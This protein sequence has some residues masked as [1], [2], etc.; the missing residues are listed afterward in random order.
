MDKQTDLEI[1]KRIAE[2]E[3]LVFCTGNRYARIEIWKD[4]KVY[5]Y[6][7]Y[8]PLTDDA[9]CFK[10]MLKY[11]TSLTYGGYA[12]IAEALIKKEDGEHSFATQAYCPKRAICLAIIA[13]KINE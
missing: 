5:K 2:I 7:K 12:V 11:E 10:L 13:S 6:E 8:N 4:G 3:G 1:C 9:L